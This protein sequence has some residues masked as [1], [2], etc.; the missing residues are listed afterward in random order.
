MGVKGLKGWL[1]KRDLVHHKKLSI[2]KNMKL[3]VDISSFMYRYKVSQGDKWLNPFVNLLT[4]LR[5]CDIHATF[6]FDG[7][8]PP[9]KDGEKKCRK[10]AKD[11]IDNKIINLEI[12]IEKYLETGEI[13]E[14]LQY[15]NTK[16][17]ETET[18][19]N[20]R[21]SRL[22]RG[23]SKKIDIEL[24]KDY[25]LK[26]TSQAIT[27]NSQDVNNAK[28]ILKNFDIEFIQAPCEAESL[29]SYLAIKDQVIGIITEDTDVLCY[30]TKVYISNINTYN[31]TCDVVY[32]DEVLKSIQLEHFSFLDFCIMCKVDYNKNIPQVGIVKAFKIIQE[33]KNID[34]WDTD[35][36]KSILLHNRCR[37]IFKTYNNLVCLECDNVNPEYNYENE[38]TSKY[39]KDCKKD[40]MKK[41]KDMSEY[42]KKYKT[43][44]WG[45]NLDF[46]SIFQFLDSLSIKYSKEEIEKAWLPKEITFD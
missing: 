2:F 3:A 13:S 40:N 18:S 1:K 44:Y 35:E 16:I 36:D 32:L 10:E 7:K 15:T 14:L 8:P 6:I 31:Y 27:L 4:N 39:C 43:Y 24:V 25:I 20:N 17:L 23:E 30:G 37:E 41:I 9:E 26:K 29:A 34:D 45:V 38:L 42:P 21:C 22:L 12:D 33:F 11:D 46:Y 28:N 5:T 19:K